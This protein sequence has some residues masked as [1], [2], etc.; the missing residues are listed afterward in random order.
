MPPIPAGG[1]DPGTFFPVATWQG[2][3]DAAVLYVHRLERNEV[4]LPGDEYE[5]ETEHLVLGEDG[6]WTSTGSCGGH[7]VNVFDPP[8]DLL[9]KYVV[10]GT[11]ISGDGGGRRRRVVHGWSVQQQGRG[12]RGDRQV[13]KPDSPGFS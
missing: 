10:L 1:I 12:S 9:E 2:D 7:W 13:R 11:G 5:D 8:A 3:R 6:Q 4:D